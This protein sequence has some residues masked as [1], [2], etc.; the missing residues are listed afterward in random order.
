MPADWFNRRVEPGA[1]ER[2]DAEYVEAVVQIEAA[3]EKDVVEQA[4]T[5]A[6]EHL[7]MDASYITTIDSENQTI[8]AV[9]GDA[10]LVER[11]EGAVIPIEQTYCLRMLNGE[12]PNVVLDTRAEPATRDLL[13]SQEFGAYVGVPVKLSDGRIHGTLCCVSRET[14]TGSVIS[15]LRFMQV[16]ADIVAARVEQAQ[17]NM[18]R[19]TERFH[20][21]AAEPS[22][23]GEPTA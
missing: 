15:D 20:A 5:A 4:L 22:P 1:Q 3:E 12:I 9:V 7:S 13:P 14:R 19:L 16:L 21:E 2:V 17:G 18:A 10:D 23:T 6:R 11:Y 8:Q